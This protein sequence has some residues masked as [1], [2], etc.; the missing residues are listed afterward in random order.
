[1][2][3]RKSIVLLFIAVY[4]CFATV[5]S[6][7]LPV[8]AAGYISDGIYYAFALFDG[9]ERLKLESVD[10]EIVCNELPVA[11]DS[12]VS[13]Y[14]SVNYDFSNPSSVDAA[15][16]YVVP[17]E[18]KPDYAAGADYAAGSGI[19]IGG[20][21]CENAIRYTYWPDERLGYFDAETEKKKLR[22][23]KNSVI[24]PETVFTRYDYKIENDEVYE[25]VYVSASITHSADAYMITGLRYSDYIGENVSSAGD[26]FYGK[27][28]INITV[29]VSGSV[30]ETGIRWYESKDYCSPPTETGFRATL[31]GKESS[32]FS[33]FIFSDLSAPPDMNETDL[34]NAATDM[35]LCSRGAGGV[36]FLQSLDLKNSVMRWY[37]GNVIVPGGGRINLRTIASV[38]PY[39]DSSVPGGRY[40]FKLLLPEKSAVSAAD[41]VALKVSAGR[42]VSVFCD[43]TAA[44][45]DNTG[46]YKIEP[47]VRLLEI[48]LGGTGNG[49]ERF[50]DYNNLGRLLI[51]F[52]SGTAL[53]SVSVAALIKLVRSRRERL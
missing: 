26:Y 44:N 9:A 10:A 14:L 15:L 51:I 12:F 7:V 45:A 41:A 39:I 27:K 40:D 6:T 5:C 17:F 34:H 50:F 4:F 52:A 20:E 42:T 19:Y 16:G 28:E 2:N 24:S 49:A 13:P 46:N 47:S 23:E 29:Y 36:S 38:F 35:I 11:G 48:T 37:A 3:K 31:V 21:K 30:D 25:S 1:M 53:A 43:G 22:E 32:T 33:E 18:N 8:S